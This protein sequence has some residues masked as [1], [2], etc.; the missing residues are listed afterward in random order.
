MTTDDR[1]N[2]RSDREEIE[3]RDRNVGGG[4]G[5]KNVGSESRRTT[6]GGQS[7]SSQ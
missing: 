7:R 6:G 5:N 3:R 1:K 2:P 4:S